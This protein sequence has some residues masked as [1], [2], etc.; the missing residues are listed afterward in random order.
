MAE[1]QQCDLCSDNTSHEHKCSEC[2]EIRQCEKKA[3]PDRN[4][5]E[6]VCDDCIASMFSLL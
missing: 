6:C 3:C 5:Y 2:G 4:D 1:Q